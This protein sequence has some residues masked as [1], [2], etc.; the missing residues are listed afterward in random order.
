MLMLGIE[1]ATAQVGVAVGGHE[2]VL[3]SAHSACDRR[4][5][6]NLT[7]QIEFVCRQAG[8]ALT[9]IAVVAVDI[10]PG[11]FTGLR[12]G[13]TAAMAVAHGLGV[14]M[15]GVS[16]LDLGAFAAAQSRRLIMP[17]Y[18]ARRGEVFTASY[19]AVPGGVQRVAEPSVSTPDELAAELLAVSEDV[20]LL[21]DGAQRYHEIFKAMGHVEFA[22]TSLDYP[23]A[24]SLVELAHP[25]AMREE[26]VQ[27]H[28]IEP[29]YIRLPD[30]E[31]NWKTRDNS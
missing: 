20:L 7:P 10:G 28:E 9:D 16:S 23:S 25:K 29:L 3:A 18:D 26:F 8:V 30:A 12:V 17:C 11:L 21:G 6:E 22:G 24:R 2:G 19:R 27:P 4:H 1:S 13:I 5:A 31:I 15:I 14:P